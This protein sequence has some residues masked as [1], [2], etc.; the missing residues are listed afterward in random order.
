MHEVLE[1]CWK[2]FVDL[3]DRLNRSKSFEIL[4]L[5]SIPKLDK[6]QSGFIYLTSKLQS[7]WQQFLHGISLIFYIDN[8][9]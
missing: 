2:H 9:I 1:D 6:K 3:I 5:L 4:S 8:S 7:H